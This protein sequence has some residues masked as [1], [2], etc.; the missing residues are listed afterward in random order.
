MKVGDLVRPTMSCG[1]Q[2]GGVRCDSALVLNKRQTW[3]SVEVD[4]YV[5]EEV[6]VHEYDLICSCGQFDEDGNFLEMI[7]ESR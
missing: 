3:K 4:A 2:L 6:E 5:Y 7:S 1:G